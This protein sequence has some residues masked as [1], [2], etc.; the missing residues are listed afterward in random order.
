VAQRSEIIKTGQDWTGESKM[1]I[2]V[3]AAGALLLTA[4]APAVP[5]QSSATV[6]AQPD[7]G[8]I[9]EIPFDPPL[10]R[11]L[12]YTFEKRETGGGR[13]GGAEFRMTVE[14]QR[15]GDEYLMTVTTSLPPGMTLGN[16]LAAALMRPTPLRVSRNGEIVGIHNEAGLWTSFERGLDALFAHG[17]DPAA[18]RAARR[19]IQEMRNLPEA[20]RISFLT[21]NI[22]PVIDFASRSLRIGETLTTETQAQFPLVGSIM[23]QNKITVE[24]ADPDSVDIVTVSSVSPEQLE[25]ATRNLVERIGVKGRSGG[26]AISSERRDRYRVSLATGLT[27]RF[28]STKTSDIEDEKGVRRRRVTSI[29]ME[30][31]ERTF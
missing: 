4:A 17:A 15:S 10:E 8:K 30:L 12:H 29:S 23:Q 1:K 6:S 2:V 19:A 26:R 20:D 31:T 3:A 25:R 5:S 16:P 28:E 24:R 27:S 13:E 21:T 9:V 11:P 7:E 22:S 18:E 14:F